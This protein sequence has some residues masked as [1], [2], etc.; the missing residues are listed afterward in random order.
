MDTEGL[1]IPDYDDLMLAEAEMQK[2]GE[3]WLDRITSSL[4]KDSIRRS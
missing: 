3:C 2:L 1:Q 4:Q